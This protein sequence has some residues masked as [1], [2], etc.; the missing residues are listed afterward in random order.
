MKKYKISIT[1]NNDNRFFLDCF[2]DYLKSP[3]SLLK[4]EEYEI[5][6]EQQILTKE[7]KT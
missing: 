1:I 3:N 2:L 5:I 7:N 4:I 6:E